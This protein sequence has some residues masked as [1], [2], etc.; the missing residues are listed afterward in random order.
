MRLR[1]AHLLSLGAL[2]LLFLSFAQSGASGAG[3][4]PRIVHGAPTP[5]VDAPFQ[6]ALYDPELVSATEPNDLLDAQFCGGVIRDATH[7]LTAAHCVT[8]GGFVAAEPQEIEVLA[9]SANLEVPEA[10]AIRDP[11]VVTSFDPEWDPSSG[12][13]DI[14]LLTLEKPLWTGAEPQ[15]DGATVQIAPLPFTS[16]FPAPGSSATVSGWGFDKPL[17]PEQEPSE[18]EQDEGHP[19]L[20]QSAAVSTLF[21]A[22]CAADYEDDVLLRGEFICA[23]GSGSPTT[24][25]CFG[26]SGGPL[27]SGTPGSPEDRLLGLVDFGEGC[28]QKQFPGVYQSVRGSLPFTASDPPQAPR[29]TSAPAI[30]GALEAGRTVTCQT[31]EWLD[32][33][34]QFSY[35]YYR[36]EA[37]ALHPFATEALTEETANPGYTISSRDVGGR[38]FCV[39]TARNAGGIGQAISADAVIAASSLPLLGLVTPSPPSAPP[40]AVSPS[41]P[42]PPSLRV[43]TAHCRRGVCTVTVSASAGAATVAKVEARLSFVRRI[44]CRKR[45]R[46]ATCRRRVSRTLAAR[47]LAQGRFSI[48][49]AGLRPGSY[50]MLLVAV[51]AAGT[52]QTHATSVPLVLRAAHARR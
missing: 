35:A 18:A 8:F 51:S 52:R 42:V 45:G 41:L 47:A 13:H 37:S 39:V 14:G 29:N 28:A 7:V 23:I 19:A 25:A 43:I 33:P 20:L 5:I 22:E 6:V 32:A 12:L 1:L 26:D 9:G 48:A 2:L 38:I 36:D 16:G 24:D 44:S 40:K 30:V 46:R 50:T 4:N 10:G 15:I 11:V 27:F 17:L 34:D 21:P 3:L 49:A 31:G